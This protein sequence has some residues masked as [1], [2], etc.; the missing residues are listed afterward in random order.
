M[1]VFD[2]FSSMVELAYLESVIQP[3]NLSNKRDVNYIT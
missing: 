3:T 1:S 2:V